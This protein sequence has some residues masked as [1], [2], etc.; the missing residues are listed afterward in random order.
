MTL[1]N[2]HVPTAAFDAIY[3]HLWRRHPTYRNMHLRESRTFKKVRTL[4]YLHAMQAT[5][6]RLIDGAISGPGLYV[7]YVLARRQLNVLV[8]QGPLEELGQ[9]ARVFEDRV[10]SRIDAEKSGPAAFTN[11]SSGQYYLRRHPGGVRSTH[12]TC[13]RAVAA[14]VLDSRFVGHLGAWDLKLLC[15]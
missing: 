7:R 13:A 1:A 14:G 6:G 8:E 4:R 12:P 15:P 5:A 11:Y 10:L 2:V 9:I 3:D